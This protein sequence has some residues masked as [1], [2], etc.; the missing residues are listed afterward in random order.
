MWTRRWRDEEKRE[1]NESNVMRRGRRGDRN[2]GQGGE[3]DVRGRVKNEV[4]GKM[5]EGR[6]NMNEED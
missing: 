1:R 3:L 4:K 6:N 5:M 2:T